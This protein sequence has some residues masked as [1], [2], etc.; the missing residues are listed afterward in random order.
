MQ[1][2]AKYGDV[3]HCVTQSTKV[4]VNVLIAPVMRAPIYTHTNPPL[5]PHPVTLP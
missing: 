1:G 3:W 2:D 5:H 4:S